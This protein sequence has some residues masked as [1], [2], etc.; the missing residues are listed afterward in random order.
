VLVGG[1][2]CPDH[3]PDFLAPTCGPRVGLGLAGDLQTDLHEPLT[4][5]GREAGDA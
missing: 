3:P 5:D 2:Q 1:S 4:V